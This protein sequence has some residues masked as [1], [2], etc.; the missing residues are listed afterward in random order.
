[1]Y[2]LKPLLKPLG[3]LSHIL[4]SALILALFAPNLQASSNL[5][6]LDKLFNARSARKTKDKIQSVAYIYGGLVSREGKKVR[7]AV[8]RVNIRG[9]A[10]KTAPILGR[11]ARG[12]T[13]VFLG[14]EKSKDTGT[15]WVQIQFKPVSAPLLAKPLWGTVRVGSKLRIRARPWGKVLGHLYNGQRVLVK[16]TKGLWLSIVSGTRSGFSHSKY[17]VLDEPTPQGSENTKPSPATSPSPNKP[18]PPPAPYTE[19]GGVAIK[20]VPRY[21][22]SPQ[23]TDPFN[24]PSGT[25][26]RPRSYCGPTS[27]QMVLSFHGIKRSRDD[28]ALTAVNSKGELV[29][30]NLRSPTYKGQLYLKG[31]GAAWEGFVRMGKHH[32]FKN[33]ELSQKGT[34]KDIRTRL[35]EGRPQIVSV[36]GPL[37]YKNGGSWT[38]GGHI[39]VVT[40]MRENGDIVINDPNRDGEKIMSA[41]NFLNVWRG[42]TIDIKK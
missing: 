38:T 40:G 19:D 5:E 26:W 23:G 31:V 8:G 37:R 41:Q 33:S 21:R 2:A 34:L 29:Q 42:V 3:S 13:F 30:K 7:V 39:M 9:A 35:K 10:S 24:P 25:S 15:T 14:N 27:L 18:R 16:K 32:G 17:I 22:Q 6:S 1:M 28:L 36:R 4:L 11:A 20:G 12:Q